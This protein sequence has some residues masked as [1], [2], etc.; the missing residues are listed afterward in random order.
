MEHDL[1]LVISKDSEGK[2]VMILAN[3]YKNTAEEIGII[4]RYRWQLELFFKWIKQHLT[5]NHLCAKTIKK[6]GKSTKGRQLHT[7]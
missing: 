2:T 1:R 3:D 5:I 6:N 4:Y 7:Q